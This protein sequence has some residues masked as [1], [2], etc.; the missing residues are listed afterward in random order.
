MV[1]MVE[2]HLSQTVQQRSQLPVLKA[3]S[4]SLVWKR[5]EA[6][7][8]QPKVAAMLI[9]LAQTM[10]YFM[11][12]KVAE[13]SEILLLLRAVVPKEKMEKAVVVVDHTASMGAKLVKVV[14]KALTDRPEILIPQR[15]RQIRQRE[16]VVRQTVIRGL[17]DQVR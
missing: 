5:R 6:V 8:V 13:V 17:V 3:E 2:I 10:K 9:I 14:I 15:L 7:M 11:T 4:L 1:M 12:G 16:L